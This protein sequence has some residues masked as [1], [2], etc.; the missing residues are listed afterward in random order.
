M[1]ER[2]NLNHKERLGLFRKALD[3]GKS[4]KQIKDMEIKQYLNGKQSRCSKVKLYQDYVFVY[5]KNAHQ[6]YT[7]Y[8]LPEELLG[9]EK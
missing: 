7:M 6:L 2:T 5:S 8:R 4:V 1:R 9:K 3:N